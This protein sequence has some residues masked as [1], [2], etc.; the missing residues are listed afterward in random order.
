MPNYQ[1]LGKK[2][3]LS[4]IISLTILFLKELKVGLATVTLV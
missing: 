1:K 4:K 2:Y 3:E